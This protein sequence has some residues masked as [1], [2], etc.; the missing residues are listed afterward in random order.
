MLG[1]HR[2]TV[3]LW[4]KKNRWDDM[5]AAARQ[6]PGII[7]QSIYDH[8]TAVNDK[9][10]ARDEQ[11]RCPTMEEV[12]KLRKLLTMTKSIQKQHTGSYMEAFHELRLFIHNRDSE[13]AGR[14]SGFIDSYL[15]GT[16]GDKE[17]MTRK[18]R[19]DNVLEATANL[20]RQEQREMNECYDDEQKMQQESSSKVAFCSSDVSSPQPGSLPA[21]PTGAASSLPQH[22]AE[23]QQ[24]CSE[25][26][27]FCSNDASSSQP[28]HPAKALHA[29]EE[30][31]E[32]CSEN[33]AS[34]SKNEQPGTASASAAKVFTVAPGGQIT[35]SGKEKKSYT[36]AV[37]ESGHPVSA[38]RGSSSVAGEQEEHA[39]E[40]TTFF[41]QAM[42]L[43]V[44]MRPSPFIDG[45]TV[46]IIHADHLESRYDTYGN[47]WGPMK[48]S[49]TIRYYPDVD[50]AKAA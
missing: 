21:G 27:A 5:K 38:A 16:M 44:H 11:D 31:Q 36:E 37:S 40:C 18:R 17:F 43:P 39:P 6:M 35:I 3:H 28:S 49:Y 4:I 25:N 24:N 23:M 20:G 8:Y 1:V 32:N 7:L 12:E 26:V 22:A 30:V 19:K 50:P 34:C 47:T 29:V 46:W 2:T 48:M 10:F 9:I 45:N 14:L 33:V 15:R 13:F 41:T 42:A